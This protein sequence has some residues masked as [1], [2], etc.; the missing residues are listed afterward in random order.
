MKKNINFIGLDFIIIVNI[1]FLTFSSRS[2]SFPVTQ[3]PVVR[4]GSA[5]KVGDHLAV[6]RKTYWVI[7]PTELSYYVFVA[8]RT[9]P[10]IKKRHQTIHFCIS[11]QNVNQFFWDHKEEQTN[12]LPKMRCWSKFG[13]LF[14]SKIQGWSKIRNLL[15]SNLFTVSWKNKI[16]CEM[17]TKY[18]VKIQSWP[19]D[20][21]K[22][23]EFSN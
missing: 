5:Q 8:Q 15:T 3:S 12:S 21:D 16:K 17:Y 20:G 4:P 18:F 11:V 23:F 1:Y 2:A 22:Y 13:F 10:P 14:W 19:L 7:E 9:D 6:T